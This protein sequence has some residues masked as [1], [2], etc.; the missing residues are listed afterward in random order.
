MAEHYFAQVAWV[1]SQ[2][3]TILGHIDQI[4][5]L[6]EGN[7]FFDEACD[8]YRRAAL[9]A[10]RAADPKETLLEINTGDVARGYRKRPYPAPFLLKAWKDMGGRVIIT[11]DSH[12]AETILFGYREAA[13]VAKAA[14]FT[15]STLLTLSGQMECVLD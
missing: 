1:A 4:V 6:N 5:K 7:R 2:K 11:A 15:R 3:P 9:D 10:L 14:G 13:E 12:R 8:R